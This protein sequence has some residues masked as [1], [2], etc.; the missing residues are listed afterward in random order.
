MGIFIPDPRTLTMAD[1]AATIDRIFHITERGSDV[2]TEIRGGIITFFAMSYILAVNPAIL[3]AAT[4]PELFGQLVTATALASAL[5]CLLMGIYANFPVA[6]APGMGINAFLSY[7]IV[8]AMGFTYTQALFIVLLSGIIFF[9]LTVTGF[10]IHVLKSIPPVMKLA[11]TAGIGFFIVV[12]GL[13]NTG[14]IVHGE[15]TAL[16]LGN[17][18]TPGTNI[19]IVCIVITLFLWA[20]DIWAAVPIGMVLT[21]I[22]GVIGGAFFDWDTV[23]NGSQL[24]PGVGAAALNDVIAM[25]DFGLFGQLFADIGEIP[26]TLFASLIVSTL[27]LVIIDMFDTTGTLLGLGRTAG[28]SDDEGNMDGYE[29]ALNVDAVAT[30]FGAFAGTSTV[31]SFIESSTGISVGAKTGLMAIVVGVLFLVAMFFSPVFAFITPACT[32]G[33]L[34]LVG[35]LMITSLKEINWH[36]HITTATVFVTLFMMGLS[37]SITDGIALGTFTYIICMVAT[38]KIKEIPPMLWVFEIIFLTYFIMTFRFVP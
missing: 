24:V 37:G 29:K 21:I 15:G 13:F 23:I 20:R 9:L 36:D 12:L 10:R 28:L 18:S 33:A 35:L 27:S 19:A 1:F 4:G 25:P 17:L 38:G 22:I 31:S 14:I 3:S 6:L 2:R 30:V 11:I 32:I 5:S 34:F 7:T 8:M 26:D 16:S